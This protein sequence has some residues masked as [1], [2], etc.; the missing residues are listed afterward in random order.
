MHRQSKFLKDDRSPKECEEDAVFMFW[1]IS[2]FSAKIFRECFRTNWL[3]KSGAPWTDD[4][5]SGAH[6]WSSESNANK[7]RC[8]KPTVEAFEAGDCN[9]WDI[10]A[11]SSILLDSTVHPLDDPED[12]SNLKQLRYWRNAFSHY[13]PN[14]ARNVSSYLEDSLILVR[15]AAN[16]HVPLLLPELEE[17]VKVLRD[18]KYYSKNP[19][20]ISE[21]LSELTSSLRSCSLEHPVHA[22]EG[23]GIF[24]CIVSRPEAE[25]C[26][27]HTCKFLPLFN[28]PCPH[29][30]QIAHALSAA[31][32]AACSS[33]AEISDSSTLGIVSL[34]STQSDIDT[35]RD[36]RVAVYVKCPVSACSSCMQLLEAYLLAYLSEECGT[37][38]QQVKDCIDSN[39]L[40]AEVIR[41][42]CTDQIFPDASV[43][44]TDSALMQSPTV[45]ILSIMVERVIPSDK[46]RS[47]WMTCMRRVRSEIQFMENVGNL[48]KKGFFSVDR[49]IATRSHVAFL[50]MSKF[51]AWIMSQLL[52]NSH[53]LK[54]ALLEIGIKFVQ[55]GLEDWVI[56]AQAGE[57]TARKML[58]RGLEAAPN[59]WTSSQVFSWLQEILRKERLG[60]I[61][62]LEKNEILQKFKEMA[63][64]NGIDGRALRQLPDDVAYSSLVKKD[65][66]RIRFTEQVNLLFKDLV[67]L[68]HSR[69]IETAG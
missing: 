62:D 69:K 56:Y 67:S 59:D 4:R 54:V 41:E 60:E 66:T 48:A 31:S 17:K 19:S 13:T 3:K 50:R 68:K 36:Q 11:L 35:E 37:L 14:S 40:L 7:K 10:C 44:V 34:D 12:V 1:L 52:R 30:T 45:R 9:G 46:C 47:L 23:P 16:K 53:G 28:T 27:L 33:D 61:S 8:M 25:A 58:K 57:V 21:L 63:S 5:I 38:F 32:S 6:Y 49:A 51:A 2:I 43:P 29:D 24:Q 20:A 64:S 22:R 39:E 18:S 26:K 55:F 65:S 15:T 42:I